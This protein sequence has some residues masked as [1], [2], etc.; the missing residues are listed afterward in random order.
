MKLKRNIILP[1]AS[2]SYPYQST[3]RGGGN[4]LPK[5]MREK[6]ASALRQELR[7]AEAAR[8]GCGSKRW[9]VPAFQ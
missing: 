6:H 2:T 5:R 9:H 7:D 4:K 1:D 8:Y 3:S